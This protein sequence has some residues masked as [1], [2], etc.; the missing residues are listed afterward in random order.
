MQATRPIR[1]MLV[2]VKDPTAQALPAL[3]KAGSSR[4]RVLDH[5]SCDLLVI[6]P[7]GFGG[8]VPRRHRGARHVS[9]PS[10]V[11]SY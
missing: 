10:G 2:A 8:K 5:L 1:R 11:P 3:E 9:L 6:K 7:R 4:V